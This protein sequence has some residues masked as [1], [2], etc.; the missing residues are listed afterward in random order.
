MNTS[1]VL[2]GRRSRLYSARAI[3]GRA[4]QSAGLALAA[5][6]R[7]S[8]RHW[9]LRCR[10]R[11]DAAARRLEATHGESSLLELHARGEPR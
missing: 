9:F 6:F 1:L 2:F 8:G 4:A 10:I 3:A 11:R 5:R 7:R